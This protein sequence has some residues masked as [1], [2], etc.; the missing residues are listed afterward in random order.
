MRRVPL[1]DD[2][3]QAGSS[4]ESIAAESSG[5]SRRQ[6]SSNEQGTSLHVIVCLPTY[7]ARLLTLLYT[8]TTTTTVMARRRR[9]PRPGAL[10]DL[11]PSRI[12]KQI[13]LL[14][15]C[16]YGV[17]IVLIVFTTFVAG[18][19]PDTKA[20]LDWRELRGDVTTGW[21]LALCWLLGSLITYAT[22][23]DRWQPTLCTTADR[24]HSVIPILLLIARSKLVPDFALTIHFIH[25]IVTSLYSH[26]VPN[27]LYW[28]F[29]Q[30][31]SA[32]L[33]I[34]LGMW[35]VNGASFNLWHLE[36]KLRARRKHRQ[37]RERD[38]RWGLCEAQVGTEVA[39][40]RMLAPRRLAR[41]LLETRQW[42][43][44]FVPL[45]QDH[46]HTTRTRMCSCI[47][48]TRGHLGLYQDHG[49]QVRHFD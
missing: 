44:V 12:I 9:P 10:A 1:V 47:K 39:V 7:K 14:Q 3:I 4:S 23:Y 19:H 5:R 43:S 22:C 13:A 49:S 27:T 18:R 34:S 33:M 6:A 48:N 41:S 38:T 21:T 42:I 29:V 11:S 37:T 8:T 25:L 16:Y 36:E 17:A 40:T 2:L 15:L 26:A 45:Y 28:W 46:R 32:A 24:A 31:A 30:A 35:H 20:I